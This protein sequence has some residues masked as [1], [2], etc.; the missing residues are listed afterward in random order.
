[1]RD[2]AEKMSIEVHVS[3]W[4]IDELVTKSLISNEKAIELFEQLL[5]TNSRLP[6]DEIEKRINKLK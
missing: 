5:I 6:K 3:I 2:V 1:M 4:I